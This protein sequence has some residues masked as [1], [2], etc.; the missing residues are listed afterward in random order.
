MTREADKK[1]YV[2]GGL[3]AVMMFIGGMSIHF[4]GDVERL[5]LRKLPQAPAPEETITRQLRYGPEYFKAVLVED[6]RKYGVAAPD[7]KKLAEPFPH[8]VEFAGRQ[9]L[10]PR[11]DGGLETKHLKIWLEITKNWAQAPG[12]GF[13]VDHAIV[14]IE[15]KT[16]AYLAY[17]VVTTPTDSRLCVNKADIPQNAIALTPREEIARTECTVDRTAAIFVTRVEVLEIPALS[18]HYLCRLRPV[19]LLHEERTSGGHLAGRGRPCDPIAW[20]DIQAGAKAKEV[21]WADVADFYARH[22][23]DEYT[24][25]RGY[26]LATSTLARLPAV[27]RPK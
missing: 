26:K 1:I 25:F 9:R 20:A 10:L 21:T 14:H 13:T 8:F 5:P 16:D 15:N 12:G 27:A 23:C 11:K 18:Y 22:S 24:F 19:I 2:A 6:A 7:P 17:N 3:L 4:S